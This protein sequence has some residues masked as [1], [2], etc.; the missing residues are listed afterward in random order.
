VRESMATWRSAGLLTPADDIGDTNETLQRREEFYALQTEVIL[1]E[2][3]AAAETAQAE[4]IL[5][6]AQSRDARDEV[7]IVEIDD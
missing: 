6:L 5:L 4:A 1:A 3:Q 7:V 2:R